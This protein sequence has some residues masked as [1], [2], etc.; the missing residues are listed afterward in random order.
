[1]I[2]TEPMNQEFSRKN[3]HPI[4]NKEAT[5]RSIINKHP[6]RIAFKELIKKRFFKK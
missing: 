6:L 5:V 1:M 3:K 2:I 4:Q